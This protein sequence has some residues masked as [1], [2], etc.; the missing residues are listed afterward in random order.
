MKLNNTSLFYILL[1]I[2]TALIPFNIF[3]QTSNDIKI[4]KLS[5]LDGKAVIKAYG[6]KKM[7]IIGVGDR[8]LQFGEVIQ[9]TKNAIVF[10]AGDDEEYEK[11]ILAIENGKQKIIKVG[12]EKKKP[13][14]PDPTFRE[15]KNVFKQ[16]IIE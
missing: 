15:N 10:K 3:A 11:I 14:P 12:G 9:I 6:S 8:I 1:L 16:Q 7:Q 13:T 4:I 5:P 2:V